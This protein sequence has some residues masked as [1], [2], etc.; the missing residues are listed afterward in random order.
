MKNKNVQ[1]GIAKIGL[2]DI[3]T[4]VFDD[5]EGNTLITDRKKHSI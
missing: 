3:G 5:F 4:L 2:T 1:V